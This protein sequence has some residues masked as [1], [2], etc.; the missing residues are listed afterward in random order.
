MTL[1]SSA[2]VD[3]P[4]A[5]A[6]IRVA[7]A[8][9]TS[10][11]VC[12]RLRDGARRADRLARPRRRELGDS[13]PR[14]LRR[15]DE[16][17]IEGD[18]VHA[19]ARRRGR[20]SGRISGRGSGRVRS[21]GFPVGVAPRGRNR[22]AA[23][24]RFFRKIR[25]FARVVGRGTVRR[26]TYSRRVATDARRRVDVSSVGSEEAR[27]RRIGASIVSRR[28]H[29]PRTFRAFR[30]TEST[31]LATQ[32]VRRHRRHRRRVLFQTFNDLVGSGPVK[33]TRRVS[34]P[35]VVRGPTRIRIG[36]RPR[37]PTHVLLRRRRRFAGVQFGDSDGLHDARVGGDDADAMAVGSTPVFSRRWRTWSRT[38][39][40]R[41][42][43][44]RPR[45]P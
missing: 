19:T 16:G 33:E 15:G 2:R 38:A 8:S 4:R 22:R 6:W 37:F 10:A 25:A 35:I 11:S 30:V 18:G 23:A 44:K 21:V 20:V 43:S 36:F 9:S 26:G 32:R 45:R 34:D 14:D 12:V 29:R 3:A 39:S 17:A 27:R 42:K 13:P 40:M 24:A 1:G 41:L 5:N 31:R 7:A 28:R